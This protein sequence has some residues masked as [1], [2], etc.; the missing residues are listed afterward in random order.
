MMLEPKTY[1]IKELSAIIGTTGKQATDR[2]LRSYR[3]SYTN[4]GHGDS[5]TYTITDI[6]DRFKVFCVFD[7]GFNPRT[8]FRKLR[9]FLFYL[10]GDDDFQWRPMELMEEYL[11][12]AGK[13]VSRQTI[14]HYIERLETLNLF[15]GG[16]FVYYRV[17][18]YFGV[19]KHEIVT[20]EEYSAAW[21]LY[22]EKRNQGY[23]SRAAYS[24]MYS[25]FEGVPRK[26]RR[27]EGNAFYIDTYNLLSEL[28]AE[29]YLLENDG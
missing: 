21:R 29:S 1:S 5:L 11:R 24:C 19:Q 28:I 9:D 10:L 25:A 7:L 27:L 3:I 4:T 6:P 23:D 14:S 20:R 17:Y 22:W 26:Q 18:K 16:D 8:D 15:S 2:K 12:K 13:G